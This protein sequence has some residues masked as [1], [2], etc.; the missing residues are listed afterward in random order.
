MSL[1]DT[2]IL[3]D[4]VDSNSKWH[5]AS[6]LLIKEFGDDAR[7]IINA[8]V[9]AEF[10]APFADY[11]FCQT[12]IKNIALTYEAIPEEAAFLTGKAFR[13]Y[14]KSGGKKSAPLPDFFIGAHALVSGYTLVT[15]DKG[16]YKTYFPKLD[17]LTPS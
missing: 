12:I 6:M 14:K 8:V 1:L 5:E 9:F 16:R 3:I 7:C 17:L 11:A 2:N 4:V 13:Q 15:R 10:S